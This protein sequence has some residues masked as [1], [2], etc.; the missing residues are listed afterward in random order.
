MKTFLVDIGKELRQ[1]SICENHFNGDCGNFTEVR[2]LGGSRLH[3]FCF[4]CAMK[5]L[6]RNLV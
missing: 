4:D 2:I 3:L 5:Y 6:K 1:V